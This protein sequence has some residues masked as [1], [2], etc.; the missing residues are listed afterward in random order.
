MARVSYLSF[1]AVQSAVK[2]GASPGARTLA[3]NA[4]RPAPLVGEQA[5]VRTGD[6]RS[7]ASL[8]P[9]ARMDDDV[10]AQEA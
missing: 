10:R 3:Y 4:K 9:G 2:L 1:G 8:D 7:A 5:A 6:F